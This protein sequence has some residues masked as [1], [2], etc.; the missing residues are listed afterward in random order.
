MTKLNE[1]VM[2]QA[3]ELTEEIGAITADLLQTIE[4][5]H[6]DPENVTENGIKKLKEIKKLVNDARNTIVKIER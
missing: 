2:D 1:M 4:F 3:I 5:I 6:Y